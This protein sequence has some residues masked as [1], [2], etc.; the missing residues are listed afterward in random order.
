MRSNLDLA[1]NAYIADANFP[2]YRMRY[3]Q[4]IIGILSMESLITKR[5]MNINIRMNC[6]LTSVLT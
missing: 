4:I 1:N 3:G 6:K 2:Q 5:Y